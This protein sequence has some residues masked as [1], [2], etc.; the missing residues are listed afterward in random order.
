MSS[1]DDPMPEP[2]L[3][4]ALDNP[5]REHAWRE[6]RE[7]LVAVRDSYTS[8]LRGLLAALLPRHSGACCTM[9]DGKVTI[10]EVSCR[11]TV[12]E[13]RARRALGEWSR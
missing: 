9:V 8:E 13:Q 7:L 1:K 3:H 4:Q 10:T 2:N 12:A 11:C 6:L 5:L